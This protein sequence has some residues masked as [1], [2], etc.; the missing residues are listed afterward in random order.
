MMRLHLQAEDGVGLPVEVFSQPNFEE[1]AKLYFWFINLDPIWSLNLAVLLVLNFF[2][3]SKALL[4]G[5]HKTGE[6]YS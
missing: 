4:Q 1:A 3:V 5:P 2:E 6:F